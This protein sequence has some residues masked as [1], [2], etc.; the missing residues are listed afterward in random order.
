MIQNK[1]YLTSIRTSLAFCTYNKASAKSKYTILTNLTKPN[2]TQFRPH[3]SKRP[4]AASGPPRIAK[5]EISFPSM[6]HRGL[7]TVRFRIIVRPG[8][9]VWRGTRPI[10]QIH[11]VPIK[12]TG[13]N[14][15]SIENN[16]AQ[17]VPITIF[18]PPDPL[19]IISSHELL[20]WLEM[21]SPSLRGATVGH[22]YKVST[23][24]II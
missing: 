2:L 14:V 9:N 20:S 1:N 10:S 3:L 16:K 23:E 19:L 7:P 5:T 11:T 4:S 22:F 17:K 12:R 6:Y 24:L 8:I 15:H 13:W 21:S 18:P